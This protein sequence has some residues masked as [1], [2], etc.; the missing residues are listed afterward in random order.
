MYATYGPGAAGMRMVQFLVGVGLVCLS[1]AVAFSATSTWDEVD[2]RVVSSSVEELPDGWFRPRVAYRYTYGGV[3]R[4]GGLVIADDTMG[5]DDGHYAS[6][7]PDRDDVTAIVQA[8]PAGA[9]VTVYVNPAIPSQ[10]VLDRSASW[11]MV[12][13][14]AVGVVA[15]VG[16]L[17]LGVRTA[18]PG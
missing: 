12:G 8:Y 13:L 6:D 15:L 16:A 9:E 7:A 18:G 3:E 2:G 17:V 5:S 11:S 14:A 10:A 4:D 1:G